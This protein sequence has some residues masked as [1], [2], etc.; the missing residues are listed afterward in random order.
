MLNKPSLRDLKREATAHALA[1][2]AFELALERGLD[3]FV[4]EDVVQRAN[5]SR[6]TFANHFSCKEE[7]VAMAALPSIDMDEAAEHMQLPDGFTPLDALRQW[8]KM[9]L[10]A[11]LLWKMRELMSISKKH[12]TLEPYILSVYKRLQNAAQETLDYF[13]QSRYPEGYT[14]LLVGAVIGAVQPIVNG[15]LHVRLP[16]DSGDE[17]D[18]GEMTFDQY[19]ET[20]FGY[21]RKGF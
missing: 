4:I 2:A 10:T 1:Q 12:P 8:M 17:R 16:G 14:H 20:T 3:G 7:A 19:L 21:L 5:Y 11:E 13:F 18:D 15:S 6:R 9:Q